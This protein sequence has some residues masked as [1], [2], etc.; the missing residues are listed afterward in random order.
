MDGCAPLHA[1]GLARPPGEDSRAGAVSLPQLRPALLP[2]A[3]RRRRTR[4]ITLVWARRFLGGHFCPQPALSRL[5]E[6]SSPK[7]PGAGDAPKVARARLAPAVVAGHEPLTN[8]HRKHLPIR[9]ALAVLV[10]HSAPRTRASVGV[11][12]F[13]WQGFD[14]PPRWLFRLGA[15]EAPSRWCRQPVPV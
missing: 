13:T 6:R 10:P 12:G 1:E 11:G 7:I 15:H 2:P 14:R 5:G 8:F 3:A 9:Q 4:R